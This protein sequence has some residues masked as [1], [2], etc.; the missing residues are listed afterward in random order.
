V[1]PREN[2]VTALL[3]VP[4]NL[5]ALTGWGLLTRERENTRC[6]SGGGRRA[7]AIRRSRG[8]LSAVTAE[9]RNALHHLQILAQTN[10]PRKIALPGSIV[11]SSV[12]SFRDRNISSRS[13]IRTYNQPVNSRLLYH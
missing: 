1:E 9:S 2:S 5:D 6:G 7:S 3:S 13:R 10:E 11:H 12:A 8:P 4:G